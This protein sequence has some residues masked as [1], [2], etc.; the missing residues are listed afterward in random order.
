MGT[1][2]ISHSSAAVTGKQYNSSAVTPYICWEKTLIVGWGST[3]LMC[4]LAQ[5][6]RDCTSHES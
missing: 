6:K 5:K 4:G 1:Q 2:S 3:K